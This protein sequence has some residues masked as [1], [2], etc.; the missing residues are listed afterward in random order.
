MASRH[1][2]V[3]ALVEQVELLDSG[4]QP[5]DR[6]TC[7]LCISCFFLSVLY[8]VVRVKTRRVE[9]RFVLVRADTALSWRVRPRNK[10]FVHVSKLPRNC[11]FL[12]VY[13][14]GLLLANYKIHHANG[15]CFKG[16]H[17]ACRSV[18]REAQLTEIYALRVGWMTF[19]HAVRFSTKDPRSVW[20]QQPLFPSSVMNER[21][22]ETTW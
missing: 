5:A 2:I 11:I 10:S 13:L 1:R 8:A 9:P 4:R 18:S 12:F 15:M 6:R 22:E 7:R 14:W 3:V 16:F 19:R 20:R 21:L 17:Q